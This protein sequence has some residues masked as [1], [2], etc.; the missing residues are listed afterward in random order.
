AQVVQHHVVTQ[1]EILAA[2]GE[3]LAGLVGGQP[4]AL[5]HCPEEVPGVL[6]TAAQ[7]LQ[8]PQL[9]RAQ[10]LA[11]A[12]PVEEGGKGR[13]SHC[14]RSSGRSSL[15]L[16]ASHRGKAH[17]PAPRSSIGRAAQ[18]RARKKTP[19]CR[20]HRAG[21]L[22]CAWSASVRAGLTAGRARSLPGSGSTAAASRR[23]ARRRAR[24]G[25]TCA[26]PPAPPAGR[27]ATPAPPPCGSLPEP[28]PGTP[29]PPC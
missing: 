24:A 29:V 28:S 8:T 22:A 16:D 14:G 15:S 7:L 9:V 19:D 18:A 3:Q 2:V 4:A 26:A 27:A 13:R 12:Q 23:R 11:S 5:E 25:R 20:A 10:E 6:V 21:R 17:S 1:Q